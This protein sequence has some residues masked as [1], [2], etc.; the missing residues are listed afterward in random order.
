M[1][2]KQRMQ[3]GTIDSSVMWL[4]GRCTRWSSPCVES[5]LVATVVGDTGPSNGT[6]H[7]ST[8]RRLQRTTPV[9]TM[10]ID[11]RRPIEGR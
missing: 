11:T 1:R 4:L 9:A 2:R 8:Q 7:N 10:I 6:D 5:P 3:H